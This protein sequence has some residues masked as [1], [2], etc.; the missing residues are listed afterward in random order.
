MSTATVPVAT[1]RPSPHAA[2]P[3]QRPLTFAS[4]V[5]SEWLKFRTLRSSWLTL[6]AGVAA[7]VVIGLVIGYNTGRNFATL[8]PE[9]AAP[10]G[11]LQATS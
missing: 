10:S 5:R 7:L 4:V 8:P 9:D 6:V 1:A 2:A 3:D 11:A